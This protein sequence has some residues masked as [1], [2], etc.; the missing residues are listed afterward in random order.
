MEHF[1]EEEHK[2]KKGFS[3]Y[4][5]QHTAKTVDDPSWLVAGTLQLGNRAGNGIAAFII[6]ASIIKRERE[7]WYCLLASITAKT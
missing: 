3:L 4:L 2:K 7:R 5:K 6:R 1:E